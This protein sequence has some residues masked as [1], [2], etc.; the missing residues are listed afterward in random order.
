ML[1]D[2]KRI[3]TINPGSTS[4][5]IGVFHNERSIFEKT[6]RHNIEELQRFDR[7]IDQ[8][9]FRKNHILETLHEQ[10]INISKFD[11]VCA[12]GGLLWPIEGGT[13]VVNDEMIEDLKSGYAGQHA[14]NLG[15]IIA[16]EI[17]DG[18]NIPSYIVDPVVVDEMSVLAKVSGMPEIERKSIFHALNQ[19]AVARK[20]AASLGKR[21][22]NMKMIITHMGGGITIGVHDRGRVVD[23]NNGLHGEG[24]FS[25]E[26]AG[27][28]PAGDLVDLCFS[29]EYTKE[30]IMKK[31]VGT[32]GLL[33][34]LGTND[35]VKVEQMIQGGDE[36]ARFIYD[37][38]AYQVA[39]EIGAASAALKGEVEAIVLTGGLAYGKSF[40]SAIRSYIDWISDVLVYPGENELQSLAQGALRVLQGEE[41]SKQYRIE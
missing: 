26:R 38:M 14:S 33:G 3:L 37:A 40:V 15:G 10:G 39:K 2:E 27:T 5:K 16:R 31:L 9:E 17:A 4:T 32:G 13:Y 29:G 1:H 24:P 21:Y 8:Y 7:I 6:L 22:E 41:Q 12:R 19:K 18:L 35:A 11:A 34:Y 36:K 20:A 30:E 28:V 23:V 25:P